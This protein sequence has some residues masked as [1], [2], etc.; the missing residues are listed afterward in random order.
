MA[1]DC[2]SAGFPSLVSLLTD[3]NATVR[4]TVACRQLDSGNTS[5]FA[6]RK[7]KSIHLAHQTKPGGL[8]MEAAQHI[9]HT[10]WKCSCKS[11]YLPNFFPFFYGTSHLE[12]SPSRRYDEDTKKE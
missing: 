2:K 8:L 9:Y 4:W 10:I 3:P 12:K 11:A 5:L 7:C 1:A 6:K